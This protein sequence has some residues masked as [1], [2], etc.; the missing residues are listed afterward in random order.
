MQENQNPNDG[1]GVTLPD[2]E[3]QARRAFLKK[4]GVATAVVPAA[5]LLLA[6]H[7]KAAQ[8][9]VVPYGDGGSGCGSGSG[10]GSSL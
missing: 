10:S 6:A 2:P 4:I 5:A 7:F 1:D 8:A 9:Q 3:V